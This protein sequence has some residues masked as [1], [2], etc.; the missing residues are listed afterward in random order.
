MIKNISQI[1]KKIIVVGGVAGGASTA[2][3]LRRLNSGINK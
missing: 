2:A 3:R 1:P